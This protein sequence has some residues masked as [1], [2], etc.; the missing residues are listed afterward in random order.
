MRTSPVTPKAALISRSATQ[1]VAR[2]RPAPFGAPRH[3]RRILSKRVDA[4]AVGALAI[5]GAPPAAIAVAGAGSRLCKHAS[6]NSLANLCLLATAYL[7]DCSALAAKLCVLPSFKLW[8]QGILGVLAEKAIVRH[9]GKACA[10]SQLALGAAAVAA[11]FGLLVWQQSRN[12]AETPVLS[13]PMHAAAS[14]VPR[15]DAVLVFG[16]SGKLGRQVVLQ[17]GLAPR[18]AVRQA[19]VLAVLPNCSAAPAAGLSCL[20]STAQSAVVVSRLTLLVSETA[21]GKAPQIN[22][23]SKVMGRARRTFLGQCRTQKQREQQ[24]QSWSA[25]GKPVKSPQA[26]T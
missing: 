22:L 23:Q 21:S 16:A 19:A 17:V 7:L 10:L 25:S 12:G 2:G 13:G 11:G 8:W 1:G 3:R 9:A 26:S 6:H 18:R 5:V 20:C 4:A 15:Q 24:C 14:E